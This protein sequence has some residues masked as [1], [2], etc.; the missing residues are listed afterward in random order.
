VTRYRQGIE[1]LAQ[2]LEDC[3]PEAAKADCARRASELQEAGV[4]DAAARR[5]AGLAHLQRAPDI[6][7]VAAQAGAELTEAAQVFF[8]SGVRF[9]IDRLI[10]RAGEL[11]AKDFFER[12]AI[13]RT[14]DQVFLAH[15]ALNKNILDRFKSSADPW[16]HWASANEN[17]IDHAAKITAELLA[18]KHFDLAKLAVAQG[19]LSDLAASRA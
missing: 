9:G 14:I 18:D 15:R 8:A 4:P 5:F 12:L 16:Q 2:R 3:L 11:V 17:R 1:V 10:S 19:L 7:Q 6:V 13:N